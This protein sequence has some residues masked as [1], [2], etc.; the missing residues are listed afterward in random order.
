MDDILVSAQLPSDALSLVQFTLSEISKTGMRV[1]LAKTV[2]FPCESMEY[3]GYLISQNS[4]QLT[5]G[6]LARLQEMTDLWTEHP[7]VEN[8]ESLIGGLV[9][10]A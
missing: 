5:S 10:A 3:V 1:N 7:T 8:L 2:L 6:R 4:I 9:S